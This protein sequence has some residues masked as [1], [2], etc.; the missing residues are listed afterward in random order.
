MKEK[1]IYTENDYEREIERINSKHER[2]V[3]KLNKHIESL[4]GIIE[5]F[6]VMVHQFVKWVVKKLSAP[7]EEVVMHK[8]ERETGTYFNIDRQLRDRTLEREDDKMER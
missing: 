3:G 5:D 1:I 7:T 8:F 4:K 6:K 2:E